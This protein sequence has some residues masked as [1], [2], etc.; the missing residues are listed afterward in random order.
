M[1]GHSWTSI[2]KHVLINPS[3]NN[4]S[5]AISSAIMFLLRGICSNSTLSNFG[6]SL[7]YFCFLFSFASYSYVICPNTSLE[8]LWMSKYL[9]PNAFPTLSPN[10][11]PSYS[12]SLLVVGN[13]SWT[14]YLSVSP[15]GVVITTPT[16]PSFGL[17]YHRSVLSTV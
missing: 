4:A 5:F 8:L 14:P 6:V 16:P 11:T 7:R 17:T 13:F 3:F 1:L 15:F 10:S 9:A 12:A 2:F